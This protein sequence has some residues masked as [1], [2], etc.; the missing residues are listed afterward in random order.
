MAQQLSQGTGWRLGWSP[1]A[2]LFQGLIGADTWAIELTAREFEDVCRLGLQLAD[3]MTAIADELMD[4]ERI[5]CEVESEWVWLEAEGFPHAYTLQVII[6]HNRRGE[7]MWLAEA[8]PELLQA[9]R[10]ISAQLIH[11]PNRH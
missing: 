6:L 4:Q 7:G 1:E 5:S 11:D 8:V 10:L 9:M 2:E 3:T